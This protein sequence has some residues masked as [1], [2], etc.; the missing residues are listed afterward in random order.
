MVQLIVRANNSDLPISCYLVSD[1]TATSIDAFIRMIKKRHNL[2]RNINI[3][4]FYN[5]T[6]LENN[7]FISDY[8]FEKDST[9]TMKIKQNSDVEGPKEFKFKN[10]DETYNL[11]WSQENSY[12]IS[13]GY[14]NALKALNTF[15]E[16]MYPNDPW[17]MV[18]DYL[19]KNGWKIIQ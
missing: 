19:T 16:D 6:P 15:N 7:K 13:E 9:I 18:I 5:N 4:L 14:D 2:K 8:N 10:W 12:A 3:Q 17:E 1:E 11:T